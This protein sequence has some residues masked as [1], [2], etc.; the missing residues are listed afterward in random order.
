MGCTSAMLRMDGAL[1]LADLFAKGL[2]LKRNRLQGGF[3]GCGQLSR[4]LPIA[5]SQCLF[6]FPRFGHDLKQC[7]HAI[8]TSRGDDAE[9]GQVSAQRVDQLRTLTD[10]Q[11]P[12]LM[13]S[14]RGLLID[15][16]DGREAHRWPCRRLADRRT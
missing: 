9:F 11:I 1:K 15:R 16:L 3:H 13:Q 10:Q 2:D 5:A 14:K 8:N 4:C 6:S 7:F 12:R